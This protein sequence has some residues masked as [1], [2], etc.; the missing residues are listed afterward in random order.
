MFKTLSCILLEQVLSP[1]GAAS[2]EFE[3]YLLSHKP[4]ESVVPPML[5]QHFFIKLLRSQCLFGES[6]FLAFISVLLFT[7]TQFQTLA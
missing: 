2:D 5:F 4:F 3:S 6:S 7:L 1:G